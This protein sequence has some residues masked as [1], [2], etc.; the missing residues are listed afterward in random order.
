[1]RAQRVAAFRDV[2][3]DWGDCRVCVPLQGADR[4]VAGAGRQHRGGRARPRR[5]AAGHCGVAGECKA[6]QVLDVLSRGT[7]ARVTGPGPGAAAGRHAR[8]PYVRFAIVLELPPSAQMG[9]ESF[10]QNYSPDRGG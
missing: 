9:P 6:A 4:S 7:G 8:L 1:M 3:G 10:E 2:S 5:R